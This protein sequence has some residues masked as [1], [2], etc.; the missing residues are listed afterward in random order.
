MALV[1]LGAAKSPL[2]SIM[3]WSFASMGVCSYWAPFWSIPS[4][5]LAGFS[6]ASGIALINSVGNL[7]GFVG[8]SIVGAAAD[9]PGGIY[10][11]LAIAGVAFFVSATLILLL[12]K[13]HIAGPRAT[14]A[15]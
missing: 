15:R 6:A 5:F 11:G 3:L 8:P 1:S 4:K 2:I 12:P 10:R 7:G 9:G 14:N 13:K